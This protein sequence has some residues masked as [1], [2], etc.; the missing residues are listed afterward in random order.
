MTPVSKVAEDPMRD[1]CIACSC[2]LEAV[3]TTVRRADGTVRFVM[4]NA[5]FDHRFCAACLT[6]FPS[7]RGRQEHRCP[8]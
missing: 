5:C 4:C 2:D 8:N 6:Y 1:T 7:A 3:R